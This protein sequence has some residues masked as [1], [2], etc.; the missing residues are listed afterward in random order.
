MKGI[1]AFRALGDVED[2]FITASLLPADA[3]GGAAPPSTKPRR[4]ENRFIRMASSGWFAASVSLL[5]AFGVLVGII[6]AGRMAPDPV[7]PVVGTT[8]PASTDTEPND[9]KETAG[10]LLPEDTVRQPPETSETQPL[11][12]APIPEPVTWT[13][14]VTVRTEL[15]RY[16]LGLTALKF[17]LTAGEPNMTIEYMGL[18]VSVYRMEGD[19]L[20]PLDV[21]YPELDMLGQCKKPDTCAVAEGE[22][23]VTFT[24]PGRYLLVAAE[25]Y[26]W[27]SYAAVLGE[28]PHERPC[29]EFEVYD[30]AEGSDPPPAEPAGAAVTVTAGSTVIHPP[31][32]LVGG[33][34]WV[35]S[36]VTDSYGMAKVDGYGLYE[37]WQVASLLPRITM[38]E[39][40]SFSV[41]TPDTT[42]RG[43]TVYG[44]DFESLFHES[45]DSLES[46]TELHAGRYYAVVTL[47][48]K[49]LVAEVN[50]WEDYTTQ[51]GFMIEV[52]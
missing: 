5:V 51:C 19:T 38:G 37:P 35:Y 39:D 18:C 34:K 21:E 16:P 44:E 10:A 33:A 12:D 47:R 48:V 24:Q 4:G 29:Y 13:Y 8:P 32:V 49:R 52:E 42:V 23:L 41:N 46:L 20:I 27:P 17:T 43:L 22:V 11:P 6:A 7:P 31:I 30:P 9:P 14:N 2:R 1:H 3:V 25:E 15:D 26:V 50:A 45:G 36:H 40:F 28:L